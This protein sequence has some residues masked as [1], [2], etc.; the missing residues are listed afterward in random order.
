MASDR[1]HP[2]DAELAVLGGIILRND[3]IGKLALAP[4]DFSE[5]F[6]RHRHVFRAMLALSERKAPIDVLTLEHELTNTKGWD[7][8]S[9]L[10]EAVGG[11]GFLAQLE[12][13]VPTS[14]AVEHY[15]RIVRE[16]ASLRRLQRYAIDLHDKVTSGA[17][18]DT[19]QSMLAGAPAI[20]GGHGTSRTLDQVPMDEFQPGLPSGIGI[21]RFVP[22]GIPRDKVTCIFGD[23]GNFK[24]TVKNA[25]LFS[26]ARAGHRCLDVSLEDPSSL[27][28]ARYLAQK[29]GLPYGQIATGQVAVPALDDQ[30]TAT[31]GR[32]IDGSQLRPRM[33]DIVAEARR[34]SV[35]AVFLDYVQLLDGCS[36][37]HT[38]LAE[39][40]RLA[41]LSAGRDG[42]AYVLVSQVKQDVRWRATNKD[43]SGRPMG[44]PWASIRDTFG[45]AA[46]STGSKLGLSV[47]R[48]WATSPLAEH[49]SSAIELYRD[50]I[51]NHSSQDYAWEKYPRILEIIVDK[52]VLG[53]AG[54]DAATVRL[55]VTPETG[56]VKEF[57]L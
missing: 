45:S 1:L 50:W 3:L 30:D 8:E 24:S 2:E 32:I 18:P 52:N 13:R 11:I 56:H 12:H 29:H 57:N 25:I 10:N 22:G 36:A 33:L 38:E 54:R 31:L 4:E 7:L 20:L 49:R 9:N 35:V 28:V 23:T 34:Q 21:E 27:T 26:L 43:K 16:S 15:A 48:P 14:E 5:H 40:V 55:E 39:S 46:I 51:D 41:Q 19:L 6:P 17:D 42:I 44:D 47:W 37:D 53:P